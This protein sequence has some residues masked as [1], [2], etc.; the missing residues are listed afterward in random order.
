MESKGLEFSEYMT[1]ESLA[2]QGATAWPSKVP[3]MTRPG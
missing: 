1:K 3:S 2:Q